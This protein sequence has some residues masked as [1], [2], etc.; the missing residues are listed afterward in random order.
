MS[1]PLIRSC[2]NYVV[3]E[4]GEKEKFLQE[5]E[6]LIWLESWLCKLEELPKDLANQASNRDAAQ[7]LLDTACELE[8]RPGFTLQWFAIRLDPKAH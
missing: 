5:K 2:S 6:T 8:I 4:P 3:L 7:R 1:D